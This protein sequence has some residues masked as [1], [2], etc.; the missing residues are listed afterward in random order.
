MSFIAPYHRVWR[1]ANGLGPWPCF[2]CGQEV[3]ELG[4]LSRG[5]WRSQGVIHHHDGNHSNNE[6]SNLRVMHH[7]CHATHH[8]TY[9]TKGI[10][11][12][13]N[14][15]SPKYHYQQLADHIRGLIQSGEFPPG[16]RLPG[17]QR[18]ARDSGVA[19]GVAVRAIGILKTEGLVIGGGVQGTFVRG[20]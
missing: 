6:L 19:I 14:A 18:I 16:A 2:G 9:E 10:H 20:G 4:A 11:A 5:P 7:G 13:M 15:A 12:R 8:M 17:V 1:K 3:A